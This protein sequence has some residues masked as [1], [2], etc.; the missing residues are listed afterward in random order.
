[1]HCTPCRLKAVNICCKQVKATTTF[2]NQKINKTWKIN[3]NT[4]YNTESVINIYGVY[5]MKP[6]VC[7]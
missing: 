1:M 5:N 2:K 7:W 4:N 6:T 3:H